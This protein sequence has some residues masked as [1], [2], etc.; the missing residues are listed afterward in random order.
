MSEGATL[1]VLGARFADPTA[2]LDAERA[3]TRLSGI[4]PS[5]VSRAPLGAVGRASDGAVIVAVRL[6]PERLAEVR[7]LLEVRGGQIVTLR[8]DETAE[9]AI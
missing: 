4:G 7:Q 6:T 5:R 9:G 1:L 8:P 2:A 3:L